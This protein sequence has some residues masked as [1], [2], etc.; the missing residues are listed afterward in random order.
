MRK[1]LPV[2]DQELMLVDGQPIVT[3]TDK[4]GLITYAN[5]AF[6]DISGFTE[7]ELIGSPHNIVRHPDMPEAAFQD[8][9]ETIK[10]GKPWIGI[11]K[12][13]AKGGGYYWVKATVT[14]Q[15]EGSDITG[16]MSVRTK[17]NRSEVQAA[18]T[19]Y[20]QINAGLAK[21]IYLQ[22]GAVR[23]RKT[24][25]GKIMGVFTGS[26][27][28][29][30]ITVIATMAAAAVVVGAIGLNGMSD[31]NKRLGRVY[32][33][34]LIPT[35]EL[36]EIK[37]LMRDNAEQLLFAAREGVE[38]KDG[39][40]QSS[41]TARIE[42]V[43]TNID[44]ITKVWQAYMAT[45]LVAEERRLAEAYQSERAAYI[46]QGVKPG[47]EMI[48]KGQFV[49]LDKHIQENVLPRFEKAKAAADRLMDL[50]QKLSAAQYETAKSKFL[51]NLIV[52]CAGLT[53]SLLLGFLTYRATIAAIN[54]PLK[55]LVDCFGSIANGNY[56][57]L[58]QVEQEDEIGVALQ[59]L[60]A[61]QAKLCFERDAAEKLQKA[62]DSE[63]EARLREEA[64]IRAE[65]E[66]E[67][68][69]RRQEQEARTQEMT[70][71]TSAFDRKIA[72]V[73]KSVD[74]ASGELEQYAGR[75]TTIAESTSLRSQAV[76]AASEQAATNVQTVAAAAEELSTSI[77]EINRQ[78]T[79]SASVTEMAVDKANQTNDT[80]R[81]LENSAGKI[82][83]VV[84]LISEIASQT[85]LLA[86]NAT[87]EAARAG[88]SGKGFAVV[89]SE[90]KNLA[91]QTAQATEDISAQVGE[92][93]SVTAE[94][95]RA[96]EEIIVTIREV[97]DVA[98][99]ISAAVEEQGAAT[100]EIARNV[101]E[102][103]NGTIE[104]SS[105]IS[106]VTSS[107][108]ETGST[109]SQVLGAA[110]ALNSQSKALRQE[111]D[112][113]LASVKAI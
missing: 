25:F 59:H 37:D 26:L 44:H 108:V 50:E 91:N 34:R 9:W 95:V 103:S 113:F 102:A 31:S 36:S 72:Q 96:I 98:T 110:E 68:E 104:V 23:E 38:Q 78:V 57:N 56:D 97:R 107:A 81:K 80:V 10:K 101:Q 4:K 1:N 84:N 58:I 48:E 2:I 69:S 83:Q 27:Q 112:E 12:N 64:A 43:R 40:V 111:V 76:A 42:H 66:A 85:N 30:L 5:Q 63:R 19:V 39:A 73:L 7:A 67:Q 93:Q 29:R 18:E 87:I 11:V 35:R 45:N 55:K 41:H 71:L 77:H 109:A 32:E 94:A 14:A 90:V 105:N 88:E 3:K 21:N 46:T 92:M 53:L 17:P 15:Q 13:R 106:G 8:L 70:R 52:I 79:Q 6:V 28:A 54:T 100:Q 86:L 16:Y 89:A 51:T 60:N 49:A 47:L 82:G 62:R 33:D 99:A 22:G 20:G 75:M 65:K 24:A 61:M 74:V